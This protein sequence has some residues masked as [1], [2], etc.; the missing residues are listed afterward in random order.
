MTQPGTGT[1]LISDPFLKDPNFMR[2]VVFLCEH[3]DQGSFGFVLNRPYEQGI[4]E[5]VP[6]IINSN[7]PV[8]YGGPVQQDTLHFL[9]RLPD[10]IPGGQQVGKNLYWGGSFAAVVQLAN[11][12]LLQP[13][14]I[15]FFIGYSGWSSG[16]LDEEM[17]GKSWLVTMAQPLLVFDT[18]PEAIWQAAIKQ[19]EHKYHEIINYPIDP[20]LN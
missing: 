10:Q 19:L 8:H 9:H 12:Y 11:A 20:Q 2:T 15:R 6:D 17:E 1:L 14:D 13:E 3:N 18:A 5:F 16:Q 4:H 7:L